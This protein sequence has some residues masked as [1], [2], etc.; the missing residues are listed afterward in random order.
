M[1]HIQK[2]ERIFIYCT[3]G[4]ALVPGCGS[5]WDV[6][7]LAQTPGREYVVGLDISTKAKEVA[8]KVGKLVPF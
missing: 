1:I 3:S 6:F 4:R 8:E 2:I 7:L 5:G